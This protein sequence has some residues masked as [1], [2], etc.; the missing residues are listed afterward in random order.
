MYL[1]LQSPKLIRWLDQSLRLDGKTL[2]EFD[3]IKTWRHN[4]WLAS[5]CL[6]TQIN[7]FRTHFFV[8]HNLYCLKQEL[9]E[10]ERGDLEIAPLAIYFKNNLEKSAALDPASKDK[11]SSHQ[12]KHLDYLAHYYLRWQPMFETTQKDVEQLFALARAGIQQPLRLHEAFKR[13]DI[14]PPTTKT[15]VTRAYRKLAMTHHPDRG[16]APATLQLIHEDKAL[17]MQ[18]LEHQ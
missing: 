5:S 11:I 10:K 15:T 14:E 4:G 3:I 17:I 7:I 1:Q 2:S 12:I 13:F 9:A 18:W 6:Q 8:Y 16:G